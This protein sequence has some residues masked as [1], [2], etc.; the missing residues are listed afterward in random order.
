MV[1]N[2]KLAQRGFTLVELLV[3][4]AIIVIISVV[5]VPD[6]INSIRMLKLN[7]AVGDYANLLQQARLR[8]VR[9]N[10]TYQVHGAGVGVLAAPYDTLQ[11]AWIDVYPQ[12]NDG[13]SGTGATGYC[14]SCGGV[15][16]ND[17]PAITVATEITVVNTDASATALK[18]AL[19]NTA[20][21]DIADD[22]TFGPRGTPCA[23]TYTAGA[24][25]CAQPGTPKQFFTIFK[26]ST[27]QRL[28]AVTVDGAGRIQRWL[29]NS[30]ANTWSNL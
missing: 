5:A 29:Y 2:R 20:T 24:A 28:E 22:P 30:T 4:V 26:S 23:P 12:N 17:D 3:V 8:A 9:D 18:N 13:S 21:I 27:N 19:G 6:A 11:Y 14:Q 16:G 7:G 25:Y 10:R 15:A 1:L